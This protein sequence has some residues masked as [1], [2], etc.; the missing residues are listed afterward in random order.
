MISESRRHLRRMVNRQNS[1]R[2]I[3]FAS[4]KNEELYKIP[5]IYALIDMSW[6]CNFDCEGCIDTKSRDGQDVVRKKIFK[7]PL[8]Y[9]PNVSKDKFLEKSIIHNFIRYAKEKNLR[10]IQLMGGETFLHPDIDEILNMLAANS[11]PIEI[12]SNGSFISKHTESLK[13]SLC[14]PNSR[15]RISVNAFKNYGR[16]IGWQSKSDEILIEVFSG[17]RKLIEALPD[18]FK[19]SIFVST[20]AFSD[21]LD[22][23]QLLVQELREI[24]LQRLLVI[25]ERD[26]EKKEFLLGQEDVENQVIRILDEIAETNRKQNKNKPFIIDIA[27]NIKIKQGAQMKEYLPCPSVFLKAFLGAD[28]FFYTC[29][30]HRGSKCAQ[31]VNIHD[32]NG[33]F[34]KAWHSKERAEKALAW[35]PKF[36]CKGL[37]CQRFEGNEFI[38]AF[39]QQHDTWTF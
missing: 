2:I 29:T 24:G 39:R 9:E 21:A 27:D 14:V 17:I 34:K 7:H 8:H 19:D 35:N 30:D 22:D 33:D 11:I 16:R 20:V 23:L 12:V 32:F 1:D 36:T 18:Q 26:P 38:N 10:G 6:N 37:V 15:L 25:R 31:L 28:G 5:P 4:A 13:N 3:Q